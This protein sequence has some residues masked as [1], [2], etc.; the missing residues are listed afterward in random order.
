MIK[1][2]HDYNGLSDKEVALKKKMHPTVLHLE[3]KKKELIEDLE[4]KLKDEQISQVEDQERYEVQLKNKIGLLAYALT[5]EVSTKK[6]SL[7]KQLDDI[8]GKGM[9][10]AT[11]YKES[12][13]S[14]SRLK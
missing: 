10:G 7:Q 1:D 9:M 5:H 6:I 14:V 12:V 4:K 13:K 11:D 3:K 2:S 8:K